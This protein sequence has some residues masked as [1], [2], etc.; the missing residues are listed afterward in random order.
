[1]RRPDAPPLLPE[2]SDA[3]G[4]LGGLVGADRRDAAAGAAAART[5]PGA[6]A[7]AARHD[8][9]YSGRACMRKDQ[10]LLATLRVRTPCTTYIPVKMAQPSRSRCVSAR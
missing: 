4:H 1:M 5:G 2:L 8:G 9:A 3:G 6:H 10:L 7:G